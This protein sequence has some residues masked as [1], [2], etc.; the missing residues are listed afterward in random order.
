MTP[1]TG[2]ATASRCIP[3]TRARL[4][5]ADLRL[6]VA[7]HGGPSCVS[8]H[9]AAARSSASLNVAPI[10]VNRARAV[11][12][13]CRR[14]VVAPAGL[15]VGVPRLSGLTAEHLELPA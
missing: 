12:L 9:P 5:G 2:D 6:Y 15:P 3:P 11:A 13:G 7:T 10:V 4:G 8:L 14:W 1:S